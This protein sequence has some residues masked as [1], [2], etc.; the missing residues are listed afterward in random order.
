MYRGTFRLNI[1]RCGAVPRCSQVRS[2]ECYA[3]QRTTL[4]PEPALLL[5][6]YVREQTHVDILGYFSPAM[7]VRTV[8][9]QNGG[10][11]TYLG[12]LML[13]ARLCLPRHSFTLCTLLSSLA[14]LLPLLFSLLFLLRWS[15]NGSM[16]GEK[17][18]E[19]QNLA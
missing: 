16:L 3:A 19:P 10:N 5:W 15:E 17:V 1:R 4:A 11:T 7:E 13:P 9:C 6:R 8:L 18:P 12:L 14:N 2:V